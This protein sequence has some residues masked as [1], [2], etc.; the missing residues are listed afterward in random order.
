MPPTAKERVVWFALDGNSNVQGE[1]W[2]KRVPST[3]L[4]HKQVYRYIAR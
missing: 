4:I 2:L 3:D 1:V